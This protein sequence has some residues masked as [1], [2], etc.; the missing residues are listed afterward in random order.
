MDVAV[1]S[2]KKNKQKTSKLSWQQSF[3]CTLT[4]P[5]CLLHA[6]NYSIC[7][8]SSAPAAKSSASLVLVGEEATGSQPSPEIIGLYIREYTSPSGQQQ[9]DMTCASSL[10]VL[11]ILLKG[12]TLNSASSVHFSWC[13]VIL[14]CLHG[15]PYTAPVLF[16]YTEY[17]YN[18][19]P[20]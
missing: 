1:D 17:S 10:S 12:N 8:I 7:N 14:A 2:K 13:M 5:H 20:F 6:A 15:L 3:H 18:N 11:I 16:H 19:C 9:K 4:S